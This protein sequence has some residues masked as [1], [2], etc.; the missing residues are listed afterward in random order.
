MQFSKS[1]MYYF[2]AESAFCWEKQHVVFLLL[3]NPKGFFIQM[4][5]EKAPS[6]CV[7]IH[8]HELQIWC[9][10]QLCR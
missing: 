6:Q 2:F 7:I 8:L 10:L 5:R 4:T 3:M 1:P 9:H